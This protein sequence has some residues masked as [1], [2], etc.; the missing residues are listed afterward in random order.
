MAAKKSDTRK[1][2]FE[3]TLKLTKET[4]GFRV[5]GNDDEDAPIPNQYIRRTVS[6]DL[7]DTI[8]VTVSV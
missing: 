5:F 1:V 6:N 8:T 3:T 7:P 4:K 2:V